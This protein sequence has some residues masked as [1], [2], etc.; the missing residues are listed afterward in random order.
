[1]KSYQDNGKEI[2]EYAYKCLER[3]KLANLEE[4]LSYDNYVSRSYSKLVLWTVMANKFRGTTNEEYYIKKVLQILNSDTKL[5][6]NS[7]Y[8]RL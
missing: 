6:F 8:K 4:F 7:D 5:V 2:K 1:M 3:N